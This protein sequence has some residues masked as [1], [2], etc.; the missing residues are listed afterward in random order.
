VEAA[1]QSAQGRAAARN[2]RPDGP[3]RQAQ[4][5]GNFF[6]LHLLHT[7]EQDRRALL[8]GKLVDGA[9]E[10]AQFKQL[11]LIGLDWLVSGAQLDP[12]ALARQAASLIDMLVMQDRE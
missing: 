3:D 12:T 11:S 9:L 6:V 4:K 2:P 8:L 10:I 7:H 5:R 1:G